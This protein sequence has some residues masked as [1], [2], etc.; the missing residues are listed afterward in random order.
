MNP[1]LK[2][3]I[4]LFAEVIVPSLYQNASLEYSFIKNFEEL[5]QGL[6][7]DAISK[8]GL[9]VKLVGVLSYIYNLKSFEKLSYRKRQKYLDKLFQFPVGKIVAGLT[10]LRSLILISYYGIEEVWTTINYNGPIKHQ[11]Q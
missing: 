8:I 11:I 10:G 7:K 6:E 1:S 2:Q 4:I 5:F 3:N 9:L